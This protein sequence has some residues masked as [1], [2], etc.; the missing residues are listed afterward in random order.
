MPPPKHSMKPKAISLYWSGG[1]M[2]GMGLDTIAEK[3]TS[4][5]TLPSLVQMP[6]CQFVSSLFWLMYSGNSPRAGLPAAATTNAAPS[7][8]AKVL[9]D[10]KRT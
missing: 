4:Q 6:E 5:T 9:A 2:H 8:M 1:G 3:N 10:P 7:T